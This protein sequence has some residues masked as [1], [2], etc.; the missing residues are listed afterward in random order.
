MD[1]RPMLIGTAA[2]VSFMTL[3]LAGA[4]AMVGLSPP[5]RP[6]QPPVRAL[7]PVPAPVRLDA[8]VPEAVRTVPAE[9]APQVSLPI[10]L[11]I[12][13]AIPPPAPVTARP[14][15]PAA[16]RP[17]R[18]APV[19][20]AALAPVHTPAHA[21]APVARPEVR[22]QPAVLAAPRIRPERE[23][24]AE[25]VV[26]SGRLRR[27]RAALRL[28]PEQEPLWRPVEQ[29]LRRIGDE[30]AALIRAGQD[31]RDAFGFVAAMRIYAVARPFLD[32]LREDQRGQVR[33]HARGMGFGSVAAQI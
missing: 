6:L 8:Q 26:T 21:P 19:R 5:A 12:A 17:R 10:S 7:P 23:G 29:A 3:A 32:A 33:A 1:W 11:P 2:S 25:G 24:A 14:A 22:P 28:T 27:F 18:E 15:P 4:F 9:P 16:E 20:V 13:S 30:Q 31:P